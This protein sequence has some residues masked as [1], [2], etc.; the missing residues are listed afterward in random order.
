MRWLLFSVFLI[1]SIRGHLQSSSFSFTNYNTSNGLADNRVQGILQD[2]RGFMWFAT[3]EGL[4]RFDGT[5]FKN[6]F[7]EP[8][9]SNSLPD[10]IINFLCE[11]K[12]D[13]LL[14]NSGGK[15]TCLNTL[16]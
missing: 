11:Y 1:S 5:T 12:P 14:L 2:S 3:A 6:F 8:G 9:N 4:S 7:A 13:H 15:L 16:T 10:N